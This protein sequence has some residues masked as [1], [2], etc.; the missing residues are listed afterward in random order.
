MFVIFLY[1]GPIPSLLP[2]SFSFS[3]PFTLFFLSFNFVNASVMFLS[4]SE[5]D[6]KLSVGI[7]AGGLLFFFTDRDFDLLLSLPLAK[8]FLSNLFIVLVKLFEAFLLELLAFP[9][10]FDTG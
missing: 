9:D 3:F 6:A 1:K 10:G 8:M 2:F 7:Y 5:D 4:S